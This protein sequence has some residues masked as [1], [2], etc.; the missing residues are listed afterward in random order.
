MPLNESEYFVCFVYTNGLV[1]AGTNEFLSS[2]G[3]VNVDHSRYM[4]TMNVNGLI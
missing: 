2:W 1:I 3:V 4:V